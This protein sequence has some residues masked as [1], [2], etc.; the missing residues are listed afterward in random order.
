MFF[1]ISDVSRNCLIS[2]AVY[3][4]MTQR[5]NTVT[6]RQLT[7]LS[8]APEICTKL[9]T[10]RNGSNARVSLFKSFIRLTYFGNYHS[11][12]QTLSPAMGFNGSRRIVSI[13]QQ[14]RIMDISLHPLT[15]FPRGTRISYKW[16]YFC[17]VR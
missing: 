10:F 11:S 9:S 4:W 2:E 7:V 5:T 16:H 17:I 15:R 6:T 14:A 12:L 3:Q 8:Q 1:G 13:K